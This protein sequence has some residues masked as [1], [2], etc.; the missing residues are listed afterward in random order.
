MQTPELLISCLFRSFALFRV[1]K[2]L[3]ILQN[4]R[5]SLHFFDS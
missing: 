4:S 3:Q 1:I 2:N 5:F